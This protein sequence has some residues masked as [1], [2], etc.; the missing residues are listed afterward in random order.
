MNFTIIDTLP[1]RPTVPGWA[2]TCERHP[3]AGSCIEQKR[4]QFTAEHYG[5]IVQLLLFPKT[6]SGWFSCS[7]PVERKKE[8][9]VI[10]GGGLKCFKPNRRRLDGD[11]GLSI[12]VQWDDPPPP[13]PPPLSVG[14]YLRGWSHHNN[15]QAPASLPGLGS[16]LPVWKLLEMWSGWAKGRGKERREE[17]RVSHY[18][19]G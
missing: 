14:V 7:C 3:L 16:Y 15:G 19:S 1:L 11:M 5:I 2:C 9:K 8:G 4:K 10:Q 17:G 13:P 12:K 18:V 6:I